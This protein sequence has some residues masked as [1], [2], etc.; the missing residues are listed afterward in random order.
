VPAALALPPA[1]GAVVVP[2]DPPPTLD[3]LCRYFDEQQIST[4]DW[5]DRLELVAELPR[6]AQGKVLRSALR[7]GLG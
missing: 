1:G 6:N 4:R 2:G 5:P 3:G 7:Q